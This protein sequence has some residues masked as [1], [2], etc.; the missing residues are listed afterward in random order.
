MDAVGLNEKKVCPL[1]LNIE[2]F[3]SF[4]MELQRINYLNLLM[5]DRITQA[6]A[7]SDRAESE[8]LS[9]KKRVRLDGRGTG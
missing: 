6:V 9:L 5:M 3:C 1:G 7:R 2:K 8:V 4:T